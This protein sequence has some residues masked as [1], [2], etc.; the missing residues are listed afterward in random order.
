[1]LRSVVR[2]PRM[3]CILIGMTMIIVMMFIHTFPCIFD[4]LVLVLVFLLPQMAKIKYTVI[5]KLWNPRF[6]EI[7]LVREF[8]IRITE[9]VVLNLI[10]I[11]ISE[12]GLRSNVSLRDGVRQ[13]LGLRHGF[14]FDSL[15]VNGQN[16]DRKCSHH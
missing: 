12:L 3:H 1:M 16:K 9:E 2:T 5:V 15:S 4:N 10:P 8:R 7:R 6:R 13:S 11:K 14:N